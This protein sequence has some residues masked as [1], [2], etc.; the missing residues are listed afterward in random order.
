MYNPLIRNN[1]FLKVAV[2]VPGSSSSTTVAGA[3]AK[4]GLAKTNR[5]RTAARIF[6]MEKMYHESGADGR[7]PLAQHQKRNGSQ[8][9]RN[10]G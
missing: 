8:Q 3:A 2:L 10:R 7:V 5:S 6:F 9:R 4:A 1:Y